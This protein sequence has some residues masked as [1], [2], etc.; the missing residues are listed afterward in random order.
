MCRSA[1]EPWQLAYLGQNFFELIYKPSYH[2]FA[3]SRK[4]SSKIF[5]KFSFCRFCILFVSLKKKF[6]LCIFESDTVKSYCPMQIFRK[7]IKYL[8]I[9]IQTIVFFTS[10]TFC[11][12]DINNKKAQ[13]TGHFQM[14]IFRA[15]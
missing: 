5:F 12:E 8:K 4:K 2:N 10:F 3:E 6:C 11:S 13:S 15:F 9:L 7:T 14:V 1:S